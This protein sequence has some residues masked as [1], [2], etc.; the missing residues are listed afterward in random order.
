ML[1]SLFSI[2][3]IAR[4]TS[5]EL[6]IA[7]YINRLNQSYTYLMHSLLVSRLSNNFIPI[8]AYPLKVIEIQLKQLL[9]RRCIDYLLNISGHSSSAI[10]VLSV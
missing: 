3:Y 7:P 2:S 9:L 6:I 1:L 5:D 8:E 10:V 4:Q